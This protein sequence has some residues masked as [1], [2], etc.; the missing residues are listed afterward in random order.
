MADLATLFERYRGA[1][2]LAALGDV[3]DR[4]APRLLALA[5]HLCGN[6]AD[7]ED[8]V[9]TAFLVAMRRA[10]TFDAR[11]PLEPWLAGLLLNAVHA[12][13][14]RG[15]I[16]RAQAL[17]DLA[18]EAHPTPADVAEREEF[19]AILR[20]HIDALPQGHRQVVLLQLQHGLA[21]AEIAEVLGQAP[22]TVRMRL[23]RGLQ[24]LRRLMPAAL[25]GWLATLL[26]ARGLDA[27]RREILR[28]ARTPPLV[29]SGAA[30]SV[31]GWILLMKKIVSLSAVL[32]VVGLCGWWGIA[33]WLDAGP[34]PAASARPGVAPLSQAV[35][36]RPEVHVAR[37]ADPSREEVASRPGALHVVVRAHLRED[38][39][40][41]GAS[42]P[43]AGVVLQV[44][45]GR[46]QLPPLG[47]VPRL[48]CTDAAGEAT[49]AALEPGRWWVLDLAGSDAEPVAVE[50]AAGQ[51]VRVDLT[52]GAA[53]V[54]RGRVVDA[55]GRPVAGAEV[56][57]LRHGGRGV[58]DANGLPEP[59]FLRERR[60]ATTG[61]DGRFVAPL[62]SEEWILGARMAGHAPSRGR[63]PHDS[64]DLDLRLG[65]APG[66]VAGRVL[67]P[68]GGPIADA[69]VSLVPKDDQESRDS[70]GTL[71]SGPLCQLA[72]S[73]AGGRFV[74]TVAA[75]RYTISAMR[76]PFY[77]AGCEVEV[78]PSGRVDADLC[79]AA[80]VLVC[81]VVRHADGSPAAAKVAA[82]PSAD[83]GAH[84]IECDT[85]ADGG[86]VLP[87]VPAR[88]FCVTVQV[89]GLR[90]A[91]AT[92]TFER[93][94]H[95]FLRADFD[96]PDGCVL[97][98]RVQREDGTALAGWTV[99]ATDARAR[100]A[101]TRTR[102]DGAFTLRQL[103][104]GELRVRVWSPDADEP[105]HELA[106]VDSYGE[107][108]VR[109]AADAMPRGEVEGRLL[110]SDGAPLSG[111]LLSLQRSDGL[112]Q[113][114]R[115]CRTGPDGGFRFAALP[116]SSFELT[117]QG[118]AGAHRLASVELAHAR[119][120]PL[121]DIVLPGSATLRVRITGA[122]GS[123]WRG[124]PPT[125]TV[126]D[127]SG[128][129][130]GVAWRWTPAAAQA[131]VPAGRHG[132]VLSGVDLLAEEQVVDLADGETRDIVFTAR[133]G[134]TR[135]LVFNRDGT[136][137]VGH[138]ETLRVDVRREDGTVVVQD[139]ACR[140]LPDLRGFR[141][142]ALRQT[143]AAGRYEVAARTDAGRFYE[144][145]FTVRD[146]PDEPSC[147]AVP[148]VAR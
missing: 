138:A 131:R 78:A 53:E 4:T 122:G 105:A 118:V 141:Y 70:T 22:G 29:G 39:A 144:G 115:T 47:A 111:T 59:L 117:V 34:P 19:V 14:R 63:Y 123:P 99:T 52:R 38:A 18:C 1:G 35:L 54:V 37:A 67:G 91:V 104:V 114:D 42:Y 135:D 121:G 80:G 49:F 43:V 132:I 79:L 23:M 77:P 44:W 89:A 10:H 137:R 48:A 71:W 24:T 60:V 64:S 120:M 112:S 73:D 146:Y 106:G 102:D 62:G 51:H 85:R 142:F 145:S 81:G 72:R 74:A 31:V 65:R 128:G 25:S 103:S 100:T 75:G 119:Q 55:D 109:V 2:D 90:E 50:L 28:S 148:A 20:Q 12:M 140:P 17:P 94:E 129:R 76:D 8:A 36:A 66:V 110:G 147:V 27:V 133:L 127:A 61:S 26:P 15:R 46:T 143:F 116:D 124:S 82:R 13:R 88:T 83:S 87:W 16:R 69:W 101:S 41:S 136:D 58:L 30:P 45:S 139:V 96:L 84:W 6:P 108:L 57:T 21:P 107:L 97:R 32:L 56:W 93:P 5:L 11:R 9:Q 113:R 130:V 40:F 125:L 98:G 33:A 134:R 86:F 7:A 92:R 68:D 3:F 95:G 126:T